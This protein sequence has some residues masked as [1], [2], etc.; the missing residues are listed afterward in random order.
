MPYLNKD[1]VVA[2]L[3]ERR[4]REIVEQHLLTGLPFVF[5]EDEALYKTFQGTLGAQLRTPIGDVSVIGSGRLGF[6]LDPERYG[7][8]FSTASDIDTI[9]VNPQMFDT[10]WLQLSLVG[11]KRFALHQRVQAAFQ[12]HRSNNVF[13]GYIEPNRLPGI[14]TLSHHWFQTFQ[15]L[16]RVRGLAQYVIHGRLYR[17]WDHVRAHQLYSLESIVDKLGL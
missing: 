6:S 4:H 13:F 10:A 7:A 1:E 12:S 15:G 5:R 8:A 14:V 9:V 2:M 17:T 3:K 16:G 11:R